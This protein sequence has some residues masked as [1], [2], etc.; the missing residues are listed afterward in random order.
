MSWSRSLPSH[1]SVYRLSF[2]PWSGLKSVWNY[3]ELEDTTCEFRGLDDKNPFGI[4][5]TEY[6]KKIHKLYLNFHSKPGS[7]SQDS[8]HPH[9]KRLHDQ[10]HYVQWVTLFTMCFSHLS[11]WLMVFDSEIS[12]W[13]SLQGLSPFTFTSIGNL[14]TASLLWVKKIQ[15]V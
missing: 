13:F 11:S 5:V 1:S 15:S 6:L 12:Q 9:E 10:V 7:H 2:F 3:F 14:W 8:F 4:S